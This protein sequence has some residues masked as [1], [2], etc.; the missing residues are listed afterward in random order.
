LKGHYE[1]TDQCCS[2]AK[3][4]NPIVPCRLAKTGEV[5]SKPTVDAARA[6][7]VICPEEA[8][9]N[10]VAFTLLLLTALLPGGCSMTLIGVGLY[11]SWSRFDGWGSFF[12]GDWDFALV[13]F[14]LPFLAVGALA[15]LQAWRLAMGRR[16]IGGL[17][18]R[19]V[20]IAALIVVG[21]TTLDVAIADYFFRPEPYIGAAIVLGVVFLALVG[22]V[23]NYRKR[24]LQSLGDLD[25]SSQI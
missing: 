15:A 12:F 22:A 21:L 11:K 10:R 23:L 9:V 6:S 18:A 2:S 8:R 3:R 7:R 17:I 19:E 14:S 1:N 24:R 5:T 16:M 13:L 20:L 25:H 4:I